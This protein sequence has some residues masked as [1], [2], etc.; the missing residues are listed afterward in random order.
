MHAPDAGLLDRPARFGPGFK[1]PAKKVLR[2]NR[3]GQGPKLF[4]AEEIRRLI[5]AAGTPLKAMLLL[6]IKVPW[7]VLTSRPPG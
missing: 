4:T 6:G 7:S 3:A 5:G 1:R 2:L